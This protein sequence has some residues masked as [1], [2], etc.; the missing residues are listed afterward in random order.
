MTPAPRTVA[1]ML[2][3]G[4]CQFIDGDTRADHVLCGAPRHRVPFKDGMKTLPYCEAHAARCY[5]K[6]PRPP[7]A[8]SEGFGR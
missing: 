3:S 1:E 2:H 4:R 7:G 8:V 6:P 5:R